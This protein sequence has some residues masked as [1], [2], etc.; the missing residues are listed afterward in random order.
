MEIKFKITDELKNKFQDELAK[1][2]GDNIWGVNIK[3][4]GNQYAFLFRMH[5]CEWHMEL[6]KNPKSGAWYTLHC[7]SQELYLPIDLIKN[8]K[9]FCQQIVRIK[10]MQS[11]FVKN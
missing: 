8:L 4:E 10:Q 5:G 6:D 3:D 2:L 9:L 7:S 11:D 1:Q